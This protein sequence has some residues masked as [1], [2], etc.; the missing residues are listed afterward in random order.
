MTGIVLC[1]QFSLCFGLLE[2]QAAHCQKK[3]ACCT[4]ECLFRTQQWKAS[5]P[6]KADHTQR[7]VPDFFPLELSFNASVLSLWNLWLRWS[8]KNDWFVTAA[9]Q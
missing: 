3:T 6:L 9:T 1:H 4:L 7:P 2:G 5:T 8:G